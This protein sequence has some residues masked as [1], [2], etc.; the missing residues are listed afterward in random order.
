VKI[1]ERARVPGIEQRISRVYSLG[2]QRNIPVLP[3]DPISV[4]GIQLA[5]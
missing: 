1:N 5:F 2:V 4:S 3:N